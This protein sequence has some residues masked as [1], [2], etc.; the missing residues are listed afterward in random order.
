MLIVP[1]SSVGMRY[2]IP[3]RKLLYS[4]PQDGSDDDGDSSSESASAAA[5]AAVLD[6]LRLLVRGAERERGVDLLESFEHF[7]R[8][9][10]VL[11]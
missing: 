6:D 1:S 11:S 4:T 8:R 10:Q 5:A 9:G 3:I 2:C 7:D